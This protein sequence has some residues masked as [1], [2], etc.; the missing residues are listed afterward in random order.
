MEFAVLVSDSVR[1]FRLRLPYAISH[2]W[3]IV[4]EYLEASLDPLDID[5]ALRIT[6]G[7]DTAR[8]Q[9]PN[10]SSLPTRLTALCISWQKTVHLLL[11]CGPQDEEPT[12]L[13]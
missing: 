10:S 8:S 12:H 6:Q 2:S 9:S 1:S 3:N 13:E 7:I 5:R 4:T 11:Q